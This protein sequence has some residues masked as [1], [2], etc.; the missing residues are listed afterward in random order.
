MRT[1]LAFHC[2]G[3]ALIATMAACNDNAFLTEVPKDFVGPEQFYRNAADATAAI[4][5]VYAA[6]IN[7]T[8]DGYYGRN[9]W[10]LVEYPTE[11]VTA[12]RLS[13]TNERSQPD[14]YTVNPTHAYIETVWSSAYSAIN[15][16]NSVLDHVPGISMDTTLQNRVLRE[17]R[18]LRALNYFNLVRL[19]G[20]VPIHVHETGG[21][22]SLLVARTPADSVYRLLE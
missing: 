8:G 19:F 14:N 12:G 10:M 18:F 2:V 15:R 13:G 1:R 5:S 9:F 11:A 20:D 17:A 21:L 22:D 7:G 6:F 3:A 16:A 4:N